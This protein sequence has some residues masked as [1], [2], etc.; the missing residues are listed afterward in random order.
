M[1]KIVAVVV[2]PDQSMDDAEWFMQ[3]LF[4]AGYESGVVNED[5]KWTLIE[6]T[7]S[8]SKVLH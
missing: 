7:E 5:Y 1:A 6:S 4:E 2:L 3:R 8:Q